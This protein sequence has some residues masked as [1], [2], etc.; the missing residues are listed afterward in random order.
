MLMRTPSIVALQSSVVFVDC[1]YLKKR[2]G[3]C[4]VEN[5]FKWD[6]GHTLFRLRVF[7]IRVAFLIV[8]KHTLKKKNLCKKNI[9]WVA[10]EKIETIS[11]PTV[12]EI[13]QVLRRLNSANSI[14]T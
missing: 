5:V 3:S 9:E 11:I 12:D 8:L 2:P 7:P 10:E 1:E 4:F 6:S 13:R 14:P